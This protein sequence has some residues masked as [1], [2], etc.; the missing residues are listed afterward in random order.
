MEERKVIFFKDATGNTNIQ[1]KLEN[2]TLWL[3]QRIM[4]QLFEKDSDTIGLHIKNIY[5]E[6][7]LEENSTTEDFSVVQQEGSRQVTRK[8]TH[9]NL[10]MIIS[11]GYRVNSKRGTQ[12]RIWANKV[13]KD[14]LVKGYVLNEQRLKE[15]SAQLDSL[16]NTVRLL[17]KVQESQT[18]GTEE[19]RGL[20]K[21]ITD[22]AYALDILDKYDHRRLTIEAI[23]PKPLFTITY[24]NA[25]KAI[26]E[27][28]EKFGGS[29]LFGNEKDESFRSSLAAIYQ[30]FNAYN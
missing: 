17:G 27:L 23:H 21:V 18:L 6:G 9:Y 19:A 20:L 5:S 12:F 10:D 11:V 24:S 7:E 8:I 15:V 1:V 13:L 14:Y 4:G 25:M 16:K 3:S 2:D 26:R 29:T 28:K 22:Y 30:S